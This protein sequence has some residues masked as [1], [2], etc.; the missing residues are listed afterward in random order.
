MISKDT[1]SSLFKRID[2]KLVD[3]KIMFRSISLS[4]SL[5]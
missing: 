1:L 4:N 2:Y 5:V 3:K